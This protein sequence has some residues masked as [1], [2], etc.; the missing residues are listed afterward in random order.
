M[1]A[2]FRPHKPGGTM[3]DDPAKPHARFPYVAA[4]LCAACIGAAVWTWMRYSYAW[5]VTPEQF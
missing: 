5:E 4:L 3:S 2:V 1:K